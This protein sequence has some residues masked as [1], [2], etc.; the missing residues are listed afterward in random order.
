MRRF[1]IPMIPCALSESPS[2]L[3]M[4]NPRQYFTLGPWLC[5]MR[6]DTSPWMDTRRESRPIDSIRDQ[7]GNLFLISSLHRYLSPLT[8]MS[9]KIQHEPKSI[10][11]WN[12]GL[13]LVEY[14][15]KSWS[16]KLFQNLDQILLYD[17]SLNLKCREV[18]CS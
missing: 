15:S 16:W 5:I 7:S 3:V 17:V 4:Q 10:W 18:N 6:K 14:F 13:E 1:I 9:V 8:V 11:G 12:A 2:L